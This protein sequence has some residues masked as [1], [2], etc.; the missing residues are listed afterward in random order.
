[1]IA[2]PPDAGAPPLCAVSAPA[3]RDATGST[4]LTVVGGHVGPAAITITGTGR[5]GSDAACA[6]LLA[7][8][9][10]Q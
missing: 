6:A 7:R 3:R 5:W 10:G 8:L 2:L 4:V 9:L 1:V